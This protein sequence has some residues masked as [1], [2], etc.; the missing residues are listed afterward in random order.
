[1]EDY[2]PGRVY[3]NLVKMMAYRNVTIT[4]PILSSDT[5]VQKLN[6]NEW[7][8]IVGTRP[9]DDPRGKATVAVVLIKPDSSFASKTAEFKKLVKIFPKSDGNLEIIVISD[10]G[11]SNHIKKYIENQFNEENPNTRIED[12]DYELFTSEKPKS[13]VMPRHEIVTTEAEEFC[14][15]MYMSPSSFPGISQNDAAAVWLGIR[16]GMVVKVHRISETAG[17][18]YAYRYC[19][20]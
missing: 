7:V 1:M 15:S 10:T 14:A 19:N 20:R 12:Y 13:D 3:E 17:K 5:L 11:L 8:S 2:E 16:V 9:G 18:S 4:E 6:N